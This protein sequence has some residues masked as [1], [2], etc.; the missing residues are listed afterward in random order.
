VEADKRV[1]RSLD[2]RSSVAVR[3]VVDPSA[4]PRSRVD[5][6][7]FVRGIA[8]VLMALDH[9]RHFLSDSISFRATDLLK[10]SGA[11]FF[12]RW[13]THFCAPIFVLL[14]GAGVR[15]STSRSKAALSRFL[16]VRGLWLILLELTFV[17]CLG[18]AFNF[19]YHYVMAGVLWALGWSMI[20]LAGLIHLPVAAVAAVGIAMIVGHDL[21]DGIRPSSLGSLAWLWKILHVPGRIQVGG[22]HFR[23]AYPLVP[24]IGVMAVGYAFAPLLRDRR[25]L[26]VGL[27]LVGI[28]LLLR[29]I[30]LYGDP[31]PWSAQGTAAFTVMSFLNCDKYPPS[32]LFL[33]MTLGPALCALAACERVPRPV[34]PFVIFGRVPLFFYLV[35]LPVIHAVA[36]VL[37]YWRHGHAEF[38]FENPPPGPR[39]AFPLPEGYGYGLHV[40]YA[41]W[42]GVVI[43]L[44]PACRWFAH[45]K[46]QRRSAVLSYL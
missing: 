11:L 31:R 17:R 9:V 25:T 34:A 36:V 2:W 19:D 13:V 44:F 43:L 46:A 29:F 26:W 30:N 28:F 39:V 6:L 3:A 21:L 24:W 37:A 15:L 27:A 8:V 10:A 14:A 12:T 45:V 40:V 5:A 1:D 33:L 7:D 35:H 18:W 32:L 16:F 22:I 20:C 23:V 38:L 42:I 4:A 41:V